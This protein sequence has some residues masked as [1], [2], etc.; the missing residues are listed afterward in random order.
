M[1]TKESDQGMVQ[2]VTLSDPELARA[3]R[4][5]LRHDK[6]TAEAGVRVKVSDG[7][8]TLSGEMDDTRRRE[9]LV[10]GIDHI[11]GVQGVSNLIL[12]RSQVPAIE[13]EA[14]REAIERALEQ[15]ADREARRIS[16]A[17][18]HGTVVL[19]GN[20]QSWAER[21]AII[22][23]AGHTPGVLAVTDH[24]HFKSQA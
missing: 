15:Q 5:A 14:I 18:D 7:W 6:D 17:I 11:P 2:A 8:V 3:V 19:S 23:A 20:V 16:V 12:I 24:L 9:H 13:P 4:L 21:C 10:R 22:D 1:I